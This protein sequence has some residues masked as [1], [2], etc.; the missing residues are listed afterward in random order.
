MA[1]VTPIRDGIAIKPPPK[2]R[3]PSQRKS[4]YDKYLADFQV[5]LGRAG[6]LSRALALALDGVSLDFGIDPCEGCMG[7]A[8][9]LDGIVNDMI[10]MQDLSG[11][12][13]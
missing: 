6:A 11:A 7:V 4:Q 2:K 3:R 1:E 13:S 5:R 12:P 9:L 8:D 10:E